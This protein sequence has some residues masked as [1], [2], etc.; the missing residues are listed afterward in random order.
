MPVATRKRGSKRLGRPPMMPEA[1]AKRTE[2]KIYYLKL[3]KSLIPNGVKILQA[4]SKEELKN[5]WGIDIPDDINW[6][7]AWYERISAILE[8]LA[9]NEKKP[10]EREDLN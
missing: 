5:R 4:K 6:E 9:R 7:K 3:P 10:I 1:R 2:G 8:T